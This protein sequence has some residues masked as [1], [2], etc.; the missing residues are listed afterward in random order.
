MSAAADAFHL[1]K[2]QPGWL[3]W[4]R[5]EMAP[6]FGRSQMTL[7]IVVSVVLVTAI[8]MALQVPQLAFL[9]RILR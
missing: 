6:F 3:A 4:L 1:P 2:Y 5:R 8:S 9:S 7:R